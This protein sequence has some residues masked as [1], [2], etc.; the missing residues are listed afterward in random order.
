MEVFFFDVELRTREKLNS[1]LIN[2]VQYDSFTGKDG[3]EYIRLMQRYVDHGFKRARWETPY[4]RVPIH[5]I[6]IREVPKL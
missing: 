6:K 1:Y 2:G 4:I 3:V 5:A